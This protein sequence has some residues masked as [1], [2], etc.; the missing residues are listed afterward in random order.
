MGTRNFEMILGIPKHVKKQGQEQDGIVSKT[1]MERCWNII[2]TLVK[3][4]VSNLDTSDN[5]VELFT[6]TPSRAK[7]HNH[8][9]NVPKCK[10][11][12]EG[13]TKGKHSHL[14]EDWTQEG[15]SRQNVHKMVGIS[16]LLSAAVDC[17]WKIA[18]KQKTKGNSWKSQHPG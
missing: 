17:E 18:T 16:K 5:S 11:V 12:I 9:T 14:L 1:Q 8:G 10:Q 3:N 7:K 4:L 2:R 13:L 6:V 15:W